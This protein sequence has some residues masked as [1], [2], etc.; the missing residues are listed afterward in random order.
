MV[1]GVVEP[2]LIM[3]IIAAVFIIV[4]SIDLNIP[5]MNG[6]A[7]I[8]TFHERAYIMD[9]ALDAAEIYIDKAALYSLYQSCHENLYNPPLQEAIFFWNVG[10]SMERHMNAYT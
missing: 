2:I 4:S 7:N 6:K 1:K 8:V 5:W 9:N 10:E 3:T